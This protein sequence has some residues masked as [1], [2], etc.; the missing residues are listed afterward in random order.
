MGRPLIRSATCVETPVSPNFTSSSV[1]ANRAGAQA[2]TAKCRKYLG[3][4]RDYIFV[5][6]AVETLGPCSPDAHKLFR[7][8]KKYTNDHK[9]GAFLV[10]RLCRPKS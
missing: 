7:Q 6:F 1:K 9:A 10:Q 5:A 4:S 8:I 2:E 3:I